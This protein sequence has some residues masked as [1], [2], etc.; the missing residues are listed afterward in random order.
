V[1]SHPWKVQKR[2]RGAVAGLGLYS[3]VP[4]KTRAAQTRPP[5]RMGGPGAVLEYQPT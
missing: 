4:P 2:R 3:V 5:A 1:F